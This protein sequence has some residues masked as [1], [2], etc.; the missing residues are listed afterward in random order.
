MP[1]LKT[2]LIYLAL[3]GLLIAGFVYLLHTAVDQSYKAGIS[4][5]KAEIA[6]NNVTVQKKVQKRYE[7]VD[8]DTPYNADKLSAIEWLLQYTRGN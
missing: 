8:K 3:I 5:C 1:W 2:H 4:Q 7:K 6:Q